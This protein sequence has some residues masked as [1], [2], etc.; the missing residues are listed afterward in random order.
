MRIVPVLDLKGGLVVRGIAG[1]RDQYRPIE[2]RLCDGSAVGDV[3]RALNWAFDFDTCYLADLDAIAGGEPNWTLYDAVFDAGL[4]IWLDAGTGTPPAAAR[5]AEYLANQNG[6]C[7]NGAGRVV[8]GLESLADG[9][10]LGAIVDAV[11]VEQL[12]FSLDLKNG[13]P[14]TASPAWRGRDPAEIADFAVSLGVQSLIVLDLAGVGVGQG[15]PTLDF[16]RR[17]RAAYPELEIT[18][19]GGVRNLA[20]LTALREA[21]CDAVLVSSALHDGRITPEGLVG[22]VTRQEG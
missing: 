19:G 10:A 15:V 12:V 11:G 7:R 8:V 3:A 20:D 5:V 2:S 21:G 18:T 13:A 17:L 6:A 9:A 16:C 1:R 4:R 14:L 22:W